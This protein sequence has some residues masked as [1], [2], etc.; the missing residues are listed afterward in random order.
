MAALGWLPLLALVN[1]SAAPPA[2]QPGQPSLILEICRIDV[3]PCQRE[4]NLAQG[5]EVTLALSV[6]SPAS[7]SPTPGQLLVA[8]H[9]RLKIEGGNVID[10]P[11]AQSTGMPIQEKPRPQAALSDMGILSAR[12]QAEPNIGSYFRVKNSYSLQDRLLEYA[13]TLVSNEVSEKAH[14]QLMPTPG[15]QVLLGTL[16]IRGSGVG[17]ARIAV[18]SINR[19]SSMLVMANSFG[20]LSV[21]DLAQQDS[22][23]WVNVGPDAEKVRLE[24]RALSDVPLAEHSHLPFTKPLSI[25]VWEQGAVPAWQG[26]T[27]LPLAT[28]S[29]VR[30]DNN[31]D[32]TVRDLPPEFIQAGTYDLRAT[33]DGMLSYLYEDLRIHPSIHYSGNLPQLISVIVGPFTSGD[34]DGDN[35]VND[36]DLS[37]LKSSFGKEVGNTDPGPLPDFN[38]DGVVDGQDFSLMAA[39]YG[40]R[41]R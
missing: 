25:E 10:L 38:A 11:D 30:P 1:A 7:S 24:G 28:F 14:P 6:R 23:A 2:S 16:A 22:L 4:V 27:D 9:L 33:G 36:N 32:F 19:G 13:V 17:T 37:L 3:S 41:G 35:L 26:G 40:M 8:W 21:T 18:D 39:N 29:N 15:E 20:E 31:G 34:L 5:E 12:A